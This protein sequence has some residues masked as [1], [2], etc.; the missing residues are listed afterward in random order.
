[1][2]LFQCD[3]RMRLNFRRVKCKIRNESL[4]DANDGLF[5]NQNLEISSFGSLAIDSKSNFSK[6]LSVGSCK[7]AHCS[8]NNCVD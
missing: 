1:M 2:K 6:S 5:D 4:V 8:K 3:T 7:E